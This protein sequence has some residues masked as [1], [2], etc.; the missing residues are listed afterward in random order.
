MSVSLLFCSLSASSVHTFT[1]VRAAALRTIRYTIST[2]KDIKAFNSL[3][4]QHLLCRSIDLMLKN[5]DERVQALKLV[6]KMLA[7]APEDISPVVVRCLVS[8]ADSGIEESDNLLRACLATLSE[9]AVLNPALLIVCGGV[10]SITRN[11]LECHNPRIAES[12]CGVL[13]YLLEWPQTRN[14][15][16]VRLDCLAAPYCD[17]TYR[18]GIMD[19][20]KYVATSQSKAG[21]HLTN[22]PPPFCRDA[23]ELR[24]T[25]CRLALLSVLRSWTGTLEFCDPSKPSGLKAIVDALYLNQ[26]EVRVSRLNS[27]L[28]LS[29]IYSLLLLSCFYCRK[30][31]WICFTNCWLCHSQA[32]L[33]TML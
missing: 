13:L 26:V 7:I 3:Q 1:Q 9:F 10:T 12:L 2:A 20:N 25:S 29:P 4:L 14:I 23:R 21:L 15:C 31:Y 17:F 28:L 27:Y 30:Q 6:R 11:V 22:L 16:G 24:Y 8:L 33:M 18:L 32:G 5:D 19:K